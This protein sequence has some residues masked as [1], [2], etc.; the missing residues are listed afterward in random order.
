MQRY[1]N[2]KEPHWK[3]GVQQC[4]VRSSR[5]LCARKEMSNSLSLFFLF[6]KV[7]VFENGCPV[8]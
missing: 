4:I 8:F 1:S 2:G 7:K 6:V 5:I 3:C